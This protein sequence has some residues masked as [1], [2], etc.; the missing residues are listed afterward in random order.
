MKVG[1]AVIDNVVIKK[2]DD[3]LNEYKETVIKSLENLT[4]EDADNLSSI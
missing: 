4:L 2:I 3:K 1:I